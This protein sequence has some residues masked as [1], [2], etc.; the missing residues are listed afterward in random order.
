MYSIAYAREQDL[1]AV[2]ALWRGAFGDDE[3]YTSWYFYTIYRPERTFCLFVGATMAA[4]LQY[5]PYALSLHGQR[6]PIAYLVGVCTA[7]PFQQQGLSRALVR[8]A[9]TQ[10]R[11]AYRL[12]LLATDI[13]EFYQSFGFCHCYWLRRHI[14]PAAATI[15]GS[16]GQW[17]AS[18][19]LD[20][21][22]DC[23]SH[24]YRRMTTHL[25][26]YLARSRENWRHFLADFF[27][28]EGGIY[29]TADAYL[30]WII[31]NG[32]LKI[33]EL[34]FTSGA[35]LMRGLSLGRQIAASRGFDSIIWDAP[36]AIPAPPAAPLLPHVMAIFCDALDSG[37]SGLIA[38]HTRELLGSSSKLWVNEIT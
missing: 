37:S 9:L 38:S 23:Y 25:D 11:A 18:G 6:L 31:E 19:I 26:G 30:L 29:L 33:K 5:A 13:P 36:L 20:D 32:V 15:P 10:L 3:P 17:R 27:C 7:P 8:Y 4:C 35:A 24:I 34:G 16:N 22:I 21:D 12:V 14:L 28:D 2:H 1:P